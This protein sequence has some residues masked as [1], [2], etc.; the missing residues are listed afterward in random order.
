MFIIKSSLT[1]GIFAV[2]QLVFAKDA[3]AWGPGVHTVIALNLIQ[4][5]SLILPSIAGIIASFPSEYLYGC[6]AADFFVGKSSVAKTASLH[7]WEGGF[8]FLEEVSDDQ[9]AAYAYGFLT[10]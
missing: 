7:N 10:H 8:R 2:I 6:L 3:L 5:V 4:D 9:E 1:I